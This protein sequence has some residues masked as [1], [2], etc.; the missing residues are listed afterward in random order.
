MKTEKLKTYLSAPLILMVVITILSSISVYAILAPARQSMGP[1]YWLRDKLE[2]V[3]G[4]KISFYHLQNFLHVPFFA[5]LT[6]L[7]L[8]FFDSAKMN[9][10]RSGI[11][12]FLIVLAF[13]FINEF[14]QRFIPG[15]V[16]SYSDVFLNMVG[17]A[18]GLMVFLG[19]KH[20]KRDPV[21]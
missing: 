18:L 1:L 4:I 2:A 6:F 10:F 14:Y 5:L 16:A 21:N 12:A 9:I 13:S 8:K 7:W 15:R 11:F 3:T 17:Y 20:R 19:I